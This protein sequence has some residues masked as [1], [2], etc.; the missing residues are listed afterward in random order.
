MNEHLIKIINETH[1]TVTKLYAKMSANHNHPLNQH[2]CRKS[3][4]FKP[5]LET[6]TFHVIAEVKRCS[7]SKG[8]LAKIE[9]P[10][11]L[12]K[13]YI[14]GNASAISVLTN[15]K[16]FGGCLEDL[17][18]IS[19]AFETTSIP[20]LRKDFIIDPIQI[21]ESLLAGADAV[22]LIVAVTQKKTR[23]LLET[24]K[25]YGIDVI[26]EV[27]TGDEL[28]YTL[29]IGA[30]LIGVNNR[31]LNT[32]AV[33]TNN[34]LQLKQYIPNHVIT[35]AESGINSL[36]LAMQ[37]KQAGFNAVLIGEALVKNRNPASFI[38][39]IMS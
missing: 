7:P 36:D 30:D 1:D 34:A 15:Q 9:N 6:N 13:Q 21:K 25:S 10:I 8:L 24:C 26:V 32:F 29:E 5:A 17:T 11:N 3:K 37:Y 38:K 27:H 23:M 33:D 16:N 2:I 31:D 20:F 12:V 4:K 22:L 18:Q 39:D 19:T 35:I 14:K 28:D